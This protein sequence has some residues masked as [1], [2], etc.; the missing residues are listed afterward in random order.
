[1]LKTKSLLSTVFTLVFLLIMQPLLAQKGESQMNSTTQP[2]ARLVFDEDL[3]KEIPRNFRTHLSPFIK[4]HTKAPSREG[5][6]NLKY[7]AS[8]QFSEISLKNVL[9]Q[10]AIEKSKIWVIDLRRESHGFINGLPISWYTP[11]NQSNYE[12]TTAEVEAAEQKLLSS[13]KLG[14]QTIEEITDKAGGLILETKSHVVDVKL[15]ETERQLVTR[16]GL[17]YWRLA[18]SDHKRPS[19]KDVDSYILFLRAL[20][21]DAWLHFHCRAGK[22]RTTTFI[23]LLDMLHNAKTVSLEDILS[24]HHLMGGANVAKISDDPEKAW[25]KEWGLERAKFLAAF[26][27]YAKQ[28]DYRQILWS[29]SLKKQAK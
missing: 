26:Y 24:R 1:M 22:G 16:L 20:P 25:K 13:L 14:N 11:Q 9:A 2:L 18:I 8:A 10:M 5:L 17:Q 3:D 29:E 4:P 27:E 7:S 23:A 19:D 12:K 28:E 15:I 6:E 21:K